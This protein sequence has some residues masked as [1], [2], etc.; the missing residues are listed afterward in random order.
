MYCRSRLDLRATGRTIKRYGKL[1]R[2]W[3]ASDRDFG[4]RLKTLIPILVGAMER[5]GHLRFD[6]EVRA[7][8]MQVSAATIDRTLTATRASIDGQRK[9]RTGVGVAIRR[10]VPV[11]ASAD[12]SDPPPRF[13]EVDTVEHCGGSK[14]GGDFVHT[15][16]LTDIASGWIECV[17]MP[18]R[19]QSLTVEA[20]SIVGAALPFDMLGVDTHKNSAFMNQTVFDYCRTHGLELTRSRAYRKNDQA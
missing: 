3:E 8:L 18:V 5:H 7:R 12:W 10:S 11:R 1:D 16:T 20:K 13:F 15:L 19:N 9:R 14:I 2:D 6:A 17:A 4:K